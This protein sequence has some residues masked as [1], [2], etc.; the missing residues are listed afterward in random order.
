MTTEFNY[1]LDS[2]GIKYCFNEQKYDLST[3]KFIIVGDNPGNT[4]Y[5]ENKFFIGSS[6]RKLRNHF[7]T[8]G[9][10]TDFE[11]ECIIFNKTFIH[12]SKTNELEPIINQVGKEVFEGI[13]LYCAR[14]IAK[15]SNDYNLPILVFGKSKIGPNLLFE[16]FWKAI[17]QFVDKKENILVFK[18]PS[19]NHFFIEWDKY[20]NVLTYKSSLDLL[21]QIGD[22]NIKLINSKYK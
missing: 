6:G 22:I 7:N 16:S 11:S 17:N 13:Q 19:Y 14:E 2:L 9:L 15:I 3:L 18:H 21:K 1:K 12:T 5:K 10:T 20:K 8:S 4:E